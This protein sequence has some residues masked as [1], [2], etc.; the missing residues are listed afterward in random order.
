MRS[1][2][3]RACHSC[4]A[5]PPLTRPAVSHALWARGHS[6]SVAQSFGIGSLGR[7]MTSRRNERRVPP[8]LTLKRPMLSCTADGSARSVAG[9]LD[10]STWPHSIERSMK[11]AAPSSLMVTPNDSR[12]DAH[13][14]GL[15]PADSGVPGPRTV[16]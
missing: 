8:T 14:T 2:T 13:S 4:T 10:T 7:S 5:A 11:Q 9:S 3:G 16:Q 1:F 12:A 15:P 6:A